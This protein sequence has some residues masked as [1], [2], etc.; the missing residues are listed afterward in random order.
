MKMTVTATDFMDVLRNH[1]TTTH[2][3]KRVYNH[4]KNHGIL[5]KRL[6]SLNRGQQEY[7]NE[8]IPNC[9]ESFVGWTYTQTLSI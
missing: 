7:A 6:R 1:F 4:C 3:S 8:R 2:E 9:N 5:D